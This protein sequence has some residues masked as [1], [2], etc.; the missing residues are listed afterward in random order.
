MSLEEEVVRLTELTDDLAE[1]IKG[2]MFVVQA[3]QTMSQIHHRR[4]SALEQRAQME[5]GDLLDGKVEL[6]PLGLLPEDAVKLV[7]ITRGLE[8]LTQEADRRMKRERR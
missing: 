4:L 7:E 3:Q 1:M 5:L 8:R 6:E 2:L